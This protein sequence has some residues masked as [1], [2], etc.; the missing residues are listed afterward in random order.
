LLKDAWRTKSWKEKLTLWF[1]PTGYRPADV[2]KK[3]PVHKIEDVY[4]FE[5]YAPKASPGLQVWSWIQISLA[6]LFISYLFGNIAPINQL[7]GSFIYMYAA[8]VFLT[9]YAYTELM[10]RNPYAIIWEA[11]KNIYALAIIFYY[12]D[13]FGA[14]QF[15]PWINY[16]L[17]AY[18]I[19]ATMVAGWFVYVHRK[20]DRQLAVS[21]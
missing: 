19:S 16:L 21:F 12:G 20:E 13:W 7:N 15:I 8:F 9:V 1:K 6:L 4:H 10:D 5:K 11:L 18:F 3:Y 2:A 17:I 14:S